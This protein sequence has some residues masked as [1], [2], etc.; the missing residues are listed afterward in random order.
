MKNEQAITI[1]DGCDPSILEAIEHFQERWQ[2]YSS[3]SRRYPI[4]RLL[5]E[6]IDPAVDAYMKTLPA[7]YSGF[8][9]GFGAGMGFSETARLVG[10]DTMVRLQ[11]KLLLHFIKT[12]NKHDSRDQRFVATIESLTEL[13][14]DCA[15]KR[16]KKSTSVVGL[17]LNTQRKHAFCELCGE[18][19]EF[20]SFMATASEEH[21][22]DAELVHEKR[23]QLSHQYCTRHRP[24]LVDGRR[25]PIYRQAKRSLAQFT[26]EL[27]R[28]SRQCTKRNMSQA[29]SGDP[30]VDRYYYWLLLSQTLQPADKAELR[31]Q[32]RLIVDTR[33][34][35][36]KKQIL[37]LQRDGLNQSDIARRLGIERQA[38]SKALKSLASLPK[39]LQLKE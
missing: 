37:I 21:V 6:V 17:N 18:F 30:L 23:L 24:I 5:Q 8:V 27:D 11:R 12:V 13:A 36:R 29:A 4:M 34:S 7:S 16:P 32:A 28:L 14:W 2:P 10:L 25:N 33:L 38:V 20:A 22:N 15:C 19:S 31:N 1:W 3:A 35:D 9:S 26:L 39:L